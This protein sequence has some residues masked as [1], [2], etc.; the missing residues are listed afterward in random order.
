MN[1]ERE[2]RYLQN[3]YP[4]KTIIKLPENN[5]KEILCEIEPT[6]SHPDWSEVVAMIDQSEPHYHRQTVE[7]YRVESGTLT[8]ILDGEEIVMNVG[9]EYTVTPPLVHF[10]RG[11]ATRVWV[12]SEPGWTPEDHILIQDYM[13]LSHSNDD[14]D[15]Q[16]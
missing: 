5:P 3:T 9:D 11:E 6:A 8:L 13:K 2:V 14:I 4:G 15:N 1:A 7:T 10:A 16:Y 12:R